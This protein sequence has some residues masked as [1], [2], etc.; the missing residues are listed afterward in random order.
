MKHKL[1]LSA[2]ACA[3]MGNLLY[4]Y[5]LYRWTVSNGKETDLLVNMAVMAVAVG[6]LIFYAEASAVAMNRKRA[7]GFCGLLGPV[8]WGLLHLL[9]LRPAGE[10]NEAIPVREAPASMSTVGRAAAV[11]LLL[12][13]LFATLGFLSD[14]SF[15][16]KVGTKRQIANERSGYLNIRRIAEAQTTYR[17]TD[18][19]SDGEK[20][21][22]QFLPH[23]WT[24]VDGKAVPVKTGLLPKAL[25]FAVNA[26]HAINGY[27]YIN[28][29]ACEKKTSPVT[30]DGHISSPLLSGKH[31][32]CF[33]V[34][35]LPSACG[36]TGRL[37]YRTKESGRVFALVVNKKTIISD[38]LKAFSPAGWVKIQSSS[39]LKAF[40]HRIR[41]KESGS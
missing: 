20:A 40:Q 36:E 30:S 8:G 25:A 41:R 34:I 33:S 12:C 7:W 6:L 5:G 19:D 26:E 4:V 2:F 27:Y 29:C 21:F 1:T 37:A 16:S 15:R 11:V 39:D 35:A 9:P 22:A 10:K 17:K 38:I 28:T 23:L 32:A 18:W 13:W 3:V 14:M 31:D 24:T